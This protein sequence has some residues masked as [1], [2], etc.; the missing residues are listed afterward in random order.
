MKIKTKTIVLGLI[1][2][3]WIKVVFNRGDEKNALG[4]GSL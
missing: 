1:K 4:E 3:D 2:T